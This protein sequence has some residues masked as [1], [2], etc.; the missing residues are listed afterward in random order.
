MLCIVVFVPLR[1]LGYAWC[2]FLEGLVQLLQRPELFDLVVDDLAEFVCLRISHH[3]VIFL[4][5]DAVIEAH[6]LRVLRVNSSIGLDGYKVTL[7]LWGT[8][9]NIFQVDSLNMNG[10]DIF[11][12]VHKRSS[13]QRSD[14]VLSL[15]AVFDVSCRGGIVVCNALLHFLLIKLVHHSREHVE[16]FVLVADFDLWDALT[17]A[18]AQARGPVTPRVKSVW[19]ILICFSFKRPVPHG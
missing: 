1:S 3:L 15:T 19:V 11:L 13:L 17:H 14:G 18:R 7:S 8:L 10:F 6:Y 16:L 2:L 4:I 12:A 9:T 5:V